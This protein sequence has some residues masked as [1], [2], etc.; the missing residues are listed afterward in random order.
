[1]LGA[2]SSRHWLPDTNAPGP[3]RRPTRNG[4]NRMRGA[5]KHPVLVWGDDEPGAQV[6]LISSS[7]DGLA[8]LLPVV[9]Q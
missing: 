2:S 7:V 5:R 6:R 9:G 8:Q 3:A 4:A 1:M